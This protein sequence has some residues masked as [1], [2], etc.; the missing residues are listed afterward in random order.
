MRLLLAEYES[1]KL[2]NRISDGIQRKKTEHITLGRKWTW[3]NSHNISPE[4]R[5]LGPKANVKNANDHQKLVKEALKPVNHRS[6]A[7]KVEY[8]NTNTDIR[9][10]RGKL[11]TIGNLHRCIH[12]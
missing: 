9:T 10:R 8:L 11:W 1:K 7:D 5:K 2:G 6:L 12:R 3:G 4:D